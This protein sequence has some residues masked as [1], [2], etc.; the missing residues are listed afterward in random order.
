MDKD[1]FL[2]LIALVISAVGQINLISTAAVVQL[3]YGLIRLL[4]FTYK[5]AFRKTKVK[6]PSSS[7][8]Q[9]GQ[10]RKRN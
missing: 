9:N 10:L 2:I 4:W 8:K 3:T 5:A 1:C 7:A 6:S